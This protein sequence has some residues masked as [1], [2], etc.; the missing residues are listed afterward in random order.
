MKQKYLRVSLFFLILTVLLAALS[1]LFLPKGNRLEDGI[2]DPALYAFLGE[3]ENS[4]DVVV[5]GDSIPL[6]SFVPAYLWED[7][8]IPSYVC[9]STAQSSA[10]SYSLL[11]TFLGRQQPVV[12]LYEAD[13]LFL[14][15]SLPELLAAGRDHIL[16]VFQYHDTWKYVRPH[17]MLSARDY[18]FVSPEKGYHMRK[19]IESLSSLPDVDWQDPSME[20]ISKTNQLIL[21]QTL[22][23]CLKHGARLVLY[24]APNATGWSV[25]RYN[26]LT[27]L[28]E[29][30][31]VPYLD[32]NVDCPEIDWTRD[33][34]DA[35]EHLNLRGAKKATQWLGQVLSDMD[36]FSDKRTDPAY[37]AWDAS[38]EEFQ[39]MAK[40]PDLYW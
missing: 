1:A 24:S 9:A 22:E 7:R 19:T 26:A 8:G 31:G 29:Q 39:A 2:Q 32:G 11:Q 34:L 16:P 25:A 38:L 13:Q 30:L 36:L 15:L 28:A 3:P 33:T 17:Q 5:I 4:L 10:S 12:V 21:R 23:L 20:P 18:T 37:A 6:C 40:D 14:N 35:G 27:A